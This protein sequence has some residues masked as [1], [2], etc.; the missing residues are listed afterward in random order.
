VLG[1]GR[2]GDTWSSPHYAW[3]IYLDDDHSGAHVY[4]NIVARVPKGGSHVHAG[5]DNLLENNIFVDNAQQQMQFSGHA[6][7]HWVLGRHLDAFKK[8]MA[9]PAYQKAYPELVDVD[10]NT[11]WH[12]AGNVFRRNILC[13]RGPDSKLYQ[14]SVRDGM[15]LRN[16]TCDEN[17]VWHYGMPVIVGQWGMKDT[18]AQLTWEQWQEKGFDR[19]SVVADPLFVDPDN[20]DYRL[21]PESPALK[22][23]FEPIP[24]DRIGPYASALRASWPIVEADGVRENP[25]RPVKVDLPEEPTRSVPRA[26]VPVAARAPVVDGTADGGEWP[27]EALSV[28]QQTTGT[29][30]QTPP[31]RLRVCHDRKNLYVAITVPVKDVD[32]LRTGTKWGDDDAAEVCFQDRSAEEPGPIFVIHGF[33]EGRHESVVEAG[34]SAEAAAT[35]GDAV[36]FAA[37]R[38]PESWTGEWCIPLK[39]ADIAYKPG[40]KLG[41]NVGVRRTEADEWIQW[42]GSGATWRLSRAGVLVLE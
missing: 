17:L 2:K 9:L 41:F 20:D 10:L 27:G 6:A 32:A 4:G 36:T 23:G 29:P 35:V 5:R 16:N 30:I 21:K 18:P 31:C 24:V 15:D 26:P 40:L 38:R 12:M 22:L 7:D 33:A 34:A 8:A 42:C 13:Y 14:C 11:I 1:Y 37:R 3:G 39:A 28:A 25:L 19:Q